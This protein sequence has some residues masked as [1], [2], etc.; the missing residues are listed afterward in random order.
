MVVKMTACSGARDPLFKAMDFR[1]AHAC[2]MN[3]PK[4][5]FDK[6]CRE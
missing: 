5:F 2:G 4:N 6:E 1:K 3:S